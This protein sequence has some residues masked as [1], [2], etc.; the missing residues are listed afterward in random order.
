MVKR[1]SRTTWVSA[2]ALVAALILPA[3][4]S[5]CGSGSDKAGSGGGGGGVGA[6]G[7]GGGVG[8]V[9]TG[10]GLGVGVGTGVGLGDAPSTVALASRRSLPDELPSQP[11][12][13][14]SR[15]GQANDRPIARTA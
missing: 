11:P 5:A 3:G 9:G 8:G 10:V 6:G 14:S 15:R 12:S 4:L 2:A 1:D 7:V 13:A